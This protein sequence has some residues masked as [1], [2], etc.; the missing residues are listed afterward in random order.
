ME[1]AI[2]DA[3]FGQL[4]RLLT[5]NKYF[6]Y[7]EEK[8]DF[9]LPDTWL[10]LLNSSDESNEKKVI[11]QDSNRSHEHSEPLSRASTQTSL[12]F[13]EARLEADEQHEIEK[14][15]SIP[16]APR[17]TKDGS[18]LVDWYYTDDSE[19]PHNWSNRK[20]ALVT[21]MICLY[22][23]VV[24]T[25][26]AIYTSSTEGII[27]EFGV[28][29][30]V[31]TLGLSLYVLGYGIGPLVFSPLSEIPVIG[32]NP[33][34]IVTMFLFV[35]IS[36]PTALVD[37]FAGLMVLR[38]LQGFF[39]SPCLASGGAS[40]GDLYSLMALPYAMMAWVSA[41]YC[42]RKFLSTPYIPNIC[43]Y[44]NLFSQPLSA[45]FSVA[46]PSPSK[47]GAGPSSNQ[48]GPPPQFSS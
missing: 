27:K 12:Q 9:K 25:T 21:T 18:I 13:T 23:F 41:A 3:P 2:R 20:R 39:G 26:S 34:Y 7:P 6:Q 47:V 24:Y 10:Q 8:P 44:T 48:S 28:S 22:T 31:A 37:N 19:N 33:V 16:I 46:L 42:G 1:S 5:N 45:L 40:I 32:R 11:Q 15:K 4:V 38:F 36:I 29:T 35:I 17:K 30:L 43:L 14:V